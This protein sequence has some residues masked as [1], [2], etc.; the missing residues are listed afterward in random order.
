MNLVVLGAGF[1]GARI[2]RAAQQLGEVVGTRRSAEGCVE[3]ERQGVKPMRFPAS[4]SVPTSGPATSATLTPELQATLRRCTHLVVSVP[5][6]RTEP[7]SD[8]ALDA[9]QALLEDDPGAMPALK[10]VGY[11]STIGVYGDHDGAWVDEDSECRSTQVRSRMRLLAERGWQ[12]FASRQGVPIA[13]LRLSG[14]YGP[15]RNAVADALAGKARRLIKPG[16]VFNRIHVDDIVSATL[17]AIRQSLG[18]VF[19]VTDDQPAPPQVVVEFA[20]AL[21][22]KE[23]PPKVDFVTADISAMARSFYSENKRVRNR[24]SRDVLGL[25]YAWPDHEA[26]LRGLLAGELEATRST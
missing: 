23:P 5:P 25:R 14:I 4:G 11:L 16:Q 10:W 26:G 15:G 12:G 2:A 18:G 17:L 20:H 7:F 9:V 1:T 22:G 21:I 13:V 6:A 19:N 3:L 8:T 24:R